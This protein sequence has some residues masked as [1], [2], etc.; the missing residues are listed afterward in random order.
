MEGDDGTLVPAKLVAV[1]E[2]V[3][4]VR[5]ARPVT[6]IG[7]PGPLAMRPPGDEVAVYEVIAAPPSDAG[8]EKVTVACWLAG[9]AVTP[10]GASGAVAKGTT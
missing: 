2:N 4:D 5:F 10:V 1:T 8:G 7:E 9:A 6:T 3:Y